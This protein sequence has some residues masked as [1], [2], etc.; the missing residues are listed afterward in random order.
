MVRRMNTLGV[1]R[2]LERSDGLPEGVRIMVPEK[3]RATTLVN[4]AVA[5]A[6]LWAALGT[7][8]ARSDEP[9]AHAAKPTEEPRRDA[10]PQEAINR[11]LCGS[12][13]NGFGPFDYRD[14]QN[15]VNINTVNTYH[16]NADVQNLI[17]GET[18][19]YVLGDLDYILRAIPNHYPALQTTSRYFLEGGK[20]YKWRT[21]EC[22]FDR[23]MRFAPDDPTVRVLY[24]IYLMKSG[25][26]EEALDEL[27]QALDL[28]PDSA[29]VQYDIGLVYFELRN[30]K[31]ANLYAARAYQGGYP[32]PGLQHKLERIG[33]WNP[34]LL[35][36]AVQSA[37]PTP[38]SGGA[39]PPAPRPDKP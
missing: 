39:Q 6:M 26:T 32:L 13:A 38:Q 35:S 17:R 9:A 18:D 1:C 11:I 8:S 10:I 36:P 7:V 33:Q 4:Y 24:G 16:F 14:P 37:T 2:Y 22:Y 12:L 3:T 31:Q 30:Y 29:E 25:K 21:M 19:E 27:M 15:R 23:A 34:P 5:A 20:R 28:N